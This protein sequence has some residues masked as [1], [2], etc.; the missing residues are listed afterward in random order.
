[1]TLAA[2]SANQLRY[3]ADRWRQE[4]AS[5]PEGNFSRVFKALVAF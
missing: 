3:V 1:M 2:S 5:I 4:A